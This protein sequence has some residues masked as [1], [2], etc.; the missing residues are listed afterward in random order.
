MRADVDTPR[1][2]LRVTAY[3]KRGKVPVWSF[4]DVIDLADDAH[5]SASRRV[6]AGRMLIAQR[7]GGLDTSA[8]LCTG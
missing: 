7:T 1:G 6:H 4:D 2:P 5:A 8:R 3:I